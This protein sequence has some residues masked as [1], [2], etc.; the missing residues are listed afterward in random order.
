MKQN[1][2][3]SKIYKLEDTLKSLAHHHRIAILSY[4]KG[5]EYASV[6]AIAQAL[7]ISFHN[8]SKHLIKLEQAHIITQE[9][10]GTHMLYRLSKKMPPLANY[11]ITKLV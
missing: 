5:H 10:N 6:G 8:T 4:L 9:K 3:P 2:Y 11:M 7:G 1:T